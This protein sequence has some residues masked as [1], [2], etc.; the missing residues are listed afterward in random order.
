MPE[1]RS[2]QY[3]FLGVIQTVQHVGEENP[4]TG[5]DS[6]IESLAVVFND[7][8]G[9]VRKITGIDNVRMVENVV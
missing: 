8:L 5:V 3:S 7:V 9:R 1:T 6:F 2:T 4:D